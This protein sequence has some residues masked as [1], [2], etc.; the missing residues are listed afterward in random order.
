[1]NRDTIKGI[2]AR[3]RFQIRNRKLAFPVKSIRAATITHP[4]KDKNKYIPKTAIIC[5]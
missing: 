4:A 5:L 1:M 3:K 2:H